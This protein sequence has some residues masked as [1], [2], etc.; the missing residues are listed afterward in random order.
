MTATVFKKK[1]GFPAVKG[2][3]IANNVIDSRIDRRICN[4]SMINQSTTSSILVVMKGFVL[5]ACYYK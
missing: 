2:L 5:L 4:T 3:N 1:L